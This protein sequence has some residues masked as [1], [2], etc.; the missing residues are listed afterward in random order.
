MDLAAHVAIALG[1]FRRRPVDC[2]R[3]SP[4]LVLLLPGAVD[5][6]L[7]DGYR[8]EPAIFIVT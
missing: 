4:E 3:F 6:D 7:G 8:P 2:D 5:V 1:T